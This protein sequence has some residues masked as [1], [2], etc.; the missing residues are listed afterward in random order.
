[1]KNLIR[2]IIGIPISFSP[3]IVFILASGILN[4]SSSLNW[5]DGLVITA[6][7]ITLLVPGLFMLL[8]E[9]VIEDIVKAI[10][11]SPFWLILRGGDYELVGLALLIGAWGTTLVRLFN[12]VLEIIL[13]TAETRVE[14]TTTNPV[15]KPEIPPIIVD[16]AILKTTLIT[17][18]LDCYAR[19]A[20]QFKYTVTEDHGAMLGYKTA[21][22]YSPVRTLSKEEW[23][24][25]RK[26]FDEWFVPL[27]EDYPDTLRCRL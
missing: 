18:M 6:I 16:E 22:T 3:L 24:I 4:E 14:P 19:E 10:M 21:D 23:E 27:S 15:R 11:I 26:L 17:D 13:G 5:S 9:S 25:T 2:T 20:W 12:V 1:M 7:V 8:G